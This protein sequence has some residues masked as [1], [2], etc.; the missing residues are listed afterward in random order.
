M[1]L[2]PPA[3]RAIVPAVNNPLARE[4][5][6]F[7]PVHLEVRDVARSVA[8]WHEIIGLT[9]RVEGSDHALLGTEDETLVTLH[10]GARSP[11]LRGHSSLYHLAIHPPTEA[12]FAAILL[13]MMRSG[14]KISPTDH[15]MSKAIYL[16]DPDG[17]TVEITLETPERLREVVLGKDSIHS[18]R[19]DG[20]LPSGVD[21]LDVQAVLSTLPSREVSAVVP[22][23]TR[24]GHVHLHVGDLMAAYQFYRWLGFDQALWAPQIG[25][26]DL[27]A[28]GAFNHRI[29]VNT[30][31]GVNVSQ[32]PAGSARMR[33]FTIRF[34]T[35]ERLDGVLAGLPTEIAAMEGGYAVKDPSGNAI[36][37]TAT[38]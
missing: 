16:L 32:S 6:T 30:W 31:Q 8:F 24:I 2:K 25:M 9:I 18:V 3:F 37:L 28:G 38:E 36:L 19:I 34:D 4:I 22:A 17:I 11:F 21:L 5:A 10:S 20:S 26:G 33:H 35:R 12:D 15:I 13:R 1:T 27:G 7:G 29:A 23:G 14:W